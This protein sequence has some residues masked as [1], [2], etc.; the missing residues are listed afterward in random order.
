V[1][2]GWPMIIFQHPISYTFLVAAIIV[3]VL[4]LRYRKNIQKKADKDD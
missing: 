2:M 3:I 4:S 1:S